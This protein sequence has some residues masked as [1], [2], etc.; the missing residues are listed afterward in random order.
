M[1]EKNI[2]SRFFKGISLIILPVFLS[3]TIVP[4]SYAQAIRLPAAVSPVNSFVPAH[5]KGLTIHPEN[6]LQFDFIV[7]EGN[8]SLDQAQL[9][10]ASAKLVKYFLASLTVPEKEMWVN[11]SPV[12]KDRIISDGLGETELGKDLLG[13]DFLLKKLSASLLSPDNKSGQEFWAKIRTKLQKD[14]GIETADLN[15]FN[16]IWIVPDAATVYEQGNSVFV[17]DSHLKV[18]CFIFLST[19]L[20]VCRSTVNEIFSFLKTKAESFLDHF[21]NSNLVVAS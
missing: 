20:N 10:D 14:H 13:Q 8:E 19:F 16:K 5:I 12:E 11:L 18:S 6:P 9:K 2:R 15:S 17:L 21:H 1:P 4:P 3:T 7:D